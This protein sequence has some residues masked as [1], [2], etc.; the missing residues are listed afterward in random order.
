MN[1]LRSLE[2]WDRGFKSHSRHGCVCAFILCLCG[3][4]PWDGLI[5]RPRCPTVCEKWLRNWI[6]GLGPEW[7]G[8]AIEIKSLIQ[9]YIWYFQEHNGTRT[10]GQNARFNFSRNRVHRSGDYIVIRHKSDQNRSAE[11][12][13]ISFPSYRSQGQLS[14][15]MYVQCICT[16]FFIIPRNPLRSK[17]SELNSLLY[18]LELKVSR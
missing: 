9:L 13:S 10:N 3:Q 12:Q 18:L 16:D 7:A 5:T 11:P 14:V 6:R 2:L 1:C 8:K 17:S 4:R 15:R